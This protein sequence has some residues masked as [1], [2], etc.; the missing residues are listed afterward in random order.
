MCEEQRRTNGNQEISGNRTKE[1]G[2][3]KL[4]KP[5]GEIKLQG[6]FK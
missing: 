2:K 6:K 4:N 3:I 5:N 1:L